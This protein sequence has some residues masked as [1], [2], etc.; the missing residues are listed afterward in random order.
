MAK[1]T[2]VIH[3]AFDPSGAQSQLDA[4]LKKQ[5]PVIRIGSM[6]DGL[7]DVGKIVADMTKQIEE[8]LTHTDFG[9][10]LAES[11]QASSG[12][13][14]S[15]I[16]D[17]IAKGI[18]QGS[19]K[20]AA[21]DISRTV[22]GNAGSNQPTQATVGFQ[23]GKTT[24]GNSYGTVAAREA[25]E[26]T[27]GV[28]H[29]TAA[30]AT[31]RY[32][33]QDRITNMRKL[34]SSYQNY[35]TNDEEKEILKRIIKDRE[36]EERRYRKLGRT[37]EADE[38]ARQRTEL[39]ALSR[40][41]VPIQI[42]LQGE[43]SEGRSVTT[44]Q[45]RGNQTYVYDTGKRDKDDNIIYASKT[46]PTGEWY[47]ASSTL[48][49]DYESQEKA[50]K[51]AEKIA[52]RNAKAYNSRTDRIS[53][54]RTQALTQGVDKNADVQNAFAAAEK[55][56][57][58]LKFDPNNAEA[59]EKYNQAMRD[60]GE[61]IAK[62]SAQQKDQE[63]T[64]KK[65]QSER[66][67]SA[68]VANQR[69]RQEE[70]KRKA[71]EKTYESQQS[72]LSNARSEIDKYQLQ[73]NK[74][75]TDAL[76][77][78]EEA[79]ATF[80]TERT[81]ESARAATE[82]YNALQ[83]AIQ[84]AAN[85]QKRLNEEAQAASKTIDSQK[86]GIAAL[87]SKA[88]NKNVDLEQGELQE[89]KK[90]LE[91]A[92]LSYETTHSEEDV[93]R[94]AD[95][96][97]DLSVA[98]DQAAQNQ[99]NLQSQAAR[100]NAF[101]K[102]VADIQSQQDRMKNSGLTF[103]DEQNSKVAEAAKKAQEAAA[104]LRDNPQDTSAPAKDTE[105]YEA[106]K[107]VIEECITAT[108][109]LNTEQQKRTSNANAVTIAKTKMEEKTADAQS[110]LNQLSGAN[111]ERATT[112]SGTL[113]AA[114]DNAK[115]KYN[116][117][118]GT[119]SDD[120][121]G[122]TA[123]LQ[124]Y[125]AAFNQ[126]TAAISS[127][128]KAL[129]EFNKESK[130]QDQGKILASKIETQKSKI[131]NFMQENR[132][133]ITEEQK[134]KLKDFLQNLNN[135][136]SPA[137]LRQIATDFASI[138]EAVKG[139]SGAVN[140][141][142]S[143]FKT[144]VKT[145]LPV[146]GG[147][148]LFRK[149][150]GEFK[151]MAQ[152]TTAIDTA[153]TSF[154]QT[155]TATS[156]QFNT[157][158]T[159]G[160]AKSKDLGINVTD[161]INAATEFSRLGESFADSAV[162][163]EAS[164]KLKNIGADI[165]DV[166][167][168]SS[169]LIATMKG[170]GLASKDV[171]RI[172]DAMTYIGNS[173]PITAGGVGDALQR[174]AASMSAAGNSMEQ[175][176]AL[177]TSGNAIVQAPERVGS[178]LN[179]LAL[180]IRGSKA[181]LSELGEETD[182][183]CESVSKMRKQVKALSGVDIML[184]ATQYKD[185]YTIMKEIS[186]VWDSLTD[187]N[188]AALTEALF[189]KMRANVGNSI[190][191]NFDIAEDVLE[192][193]TSGKAAGYTESAYGTYLDSV[194]AKAQQLKTTFQE[195]S[196]VIADSNLLKAGYDIGTTV[197]ES[198]TA[199]VKA[200]TSLSNTLGLANSSLG[201]L[202]GL[203]TVAFTALSKLS[204]VPLWDFSGNGKGLIN[205]VRITGAQANALRTVQDNNYGILSPYFQTGLVPSGQGLHIGDLPQS[206][207]EGLHNAGAYLS[208]MRTEAGMT[209]EQLDQ[210]YQKQRGIIHA[211]VQLGSQ[212]GSVWSNIAKGLKSTILQMGIVYIA[213]LGIS[214]LANAIDKSVNAR[215]YSMQAAEE[216]YKNSR[217]VQ[218]EIETRNKTVE[219][220]IDVV[221]KYRDKVGAK[222]ENLGLSTDEMAEYQAAANA[223]GE[224]LPDLV[225]YWDES[226]NAVLRA[227]DKVDQ[228]TEALQR[229]NLVTL[230]T[231]W[232]EDA[233]DL[234]KGANA[235]VNNKNTDWKSVWAGDP[236]D[237]TNVN[238]YNNAVNYVGE[239]SVVAAIN[240]ILSTVD[241]PKERRRQ[242]S[243]L[244]QNVYKNVN[245]GL[246]YERIHGRS[247][248]EVLYGD[249]DDLAQVDSWKRQGYDMEQY[250]APWFFTQMAKNGSP[251]SSNIRFDDKSWG[252]F[253]G[254][255][256]SASS[257]WNSITTKAGSQLNSVALRSFDI[258]TNPFSRYSI[259]GG[260]SNIQADT[261]AIVRRAIAGMDLSDLLGI[262]ASNANDIS[263]Y[264]ENSILKPLVSGS[265]YQQALTEFST[266]AS[267][268]DT[269]T[270]T[271]GQ[272]NAARQRAKTAADEADLN[273]DIADAIAD[274]VFDSDYYGDRVAHVTDLISDEWDGF[275]ES[276]TKPMLDFA[277]GIDLFDGNKQV[278][279]TMDQFF[280]AYAEFLNNMNNQWSDMK[281]TVEKMNE[282]QKTF[283]TV[284]SN[285][286]KNGYLS[287]EDVDSVLAAN[288]A[289][290]G[291]LKYGVGGY[292]FDQE[293]AQQ[294]MS[295]E[296][297]VLMDENSA[298]IGRNSEAI[299]KAEQKLAALGE[300]TENETA[301][302][303]KQR[304]THQETIDTLKKENNRRAM[305][306]EQ[307]AF[308]DTP[309]GRWLAMQDSPEAG[310]GFRGLKGAVDAVR[311]GV[312]TGR[313]FTTAFKTSGDV[314]FGEDSGW[315]DWD[316][317][318]VDKKLKSFEKL[319]D[320]NGQFSVGNM[321][322]WFQAAG[323][324]NENG[325]WTRT[326]TFD[327]LAD[328][329]AQDVE[330]FGPMGKQ[331]LAQVLMAASEYVGWDQLGFKPE[332]LTEFL[333][334]T[335]EEDANTTAVNANTVA[336]N[337][338]TAALGGIVSEGGLTE[339]GNIT[340]EK[341][342]T[343]I[344]VET[345]PDE[346]GK[347]SVVGKDAE[348]NTVGSYG[349]FK[350][351]TTAQ[352]VA[353]IIDAA[354][355]RGIYYTA[356]DIEKISQTSN[357]DWSTFAQSQLT[358]GSQLITS[359][360]NLNG[361]ADALT[362]AAGV[363]EEAVGGGSSGSGGEGEGKGENAG[364]EPHYEP[365]TKETKDYW[366]Q[367]DKLYKASAANAEKKELAEAA[368]AKAYEDGVKRTEQIKAHA[369][370]EE[371]QEQLRQDIDDDWL[372]K[373][374][375]HQEALQ[376]E[377]IDGEVKS[378]HERLMSDLREQGSTEAEKLKAQR[379]AQRET[380]AERREAE[381][382]APQKAA[383]T[384]YSIQ[385]R[386]Q[387][388]KKA[389]EI[390]QK[391]IQPALTERQDLINDITDILATDKSMA[392][393]KWFRDN[394]GVD[395]SRDLEAYDNETL[396]T[397]L[398]QLTDVVTQ[399]A[400][401][402]AQRDG[403]KRTQQV[404]EAQEEAEW[405]TT[406][407][408]HQESLRQDIIKG[409][410][411]QLWE[412]AIAANNKLKEATVE[413]QNATIETP[414]TTEPEIPSMTLSPESMN[415]PASYY[416]ALKNGLATNDYG[417]Y[418]LPTLYALE[419]G[420]SDMIN[421]IDDQFDWDSYDVLGTKDQAAMLMNWLVDHSGG[422]LPESAKQPLSTDEVTV[423]ADSTVVESPAPPETT[424]PEPT[425]APEKTYENFEEPYGGYNSPYTYAL[426]TGLFDR[427][428]ELEELT[429]DLFDWDAFD[430][431]SSADQM[432]TFDSWISSHQ[433][434]QDTSIDADN[435]GFMEAN[436]EVEA[437]GEEPVTKPINGD[438]SGANAAIDQIRAKAAEGAQMPITIITPDTSGGSNSSTEDGDSFASGIPS[439]P[440]GPSLVGEAGD[441]I[442]VDT[443]RGSW[444]L[445]Q[446]PEL[447]N[448]N[449][450]DIVYNAK[451]TSELLRR[452]QA[453]GGSAHAK[454]L[455]GNAYEGGLFAQIWQ[456]FVGLWSN[457]NKKPSG[458]SGGGNKDSG[459]AA[460]EMTD[461]FNKL[462][463]WIERLLAVAKEKTDKLVDSVK[464]LVN[465][466]S[467]NNR[468]DQAI[469]AAQ[470]EQKVNRR[471]AARYR[472]QADDTAK[473]YGLSASYV[474]KIQEGKLD[475]ESLSEET[476]AKVAEYKKWY[477]KALA[478]ESRIEEL[479][480]QIKELQLSKFDNIVDYYTG[481]VDYRKSLQAVSSANV[482]YKNASGKTLTKYDFTPQLHA[483]GF[484]RSNLQS[485]RDAMQKQFDDLIK[486]GTIREG[487]EN[488]YKYK[489]AI[490]DLDEQILKADTDIQKVQDEINR[491][492]LTKL[493]YALNALKRIST[494]IQNIFSLN[495]AQN[496]TP[497]TDEE[498]DTTTGYYNDLIKNGMKQIKN[499]KDQRK[500]LVGMLDGLDKNSE[501]YQEILGEIDQI[502]ASIASVM[503]DQEQW[504]D[505]II[506][507]QIE[508][509][510][511]QREELEKQND[512]YKKQKEYEEAL[513]ELEKART[514]KTKLIFREGKGFQY[515]ADED[516]IRE[517]Q[518]RVDDLRHQQIIDKIDEV[519]D[520][521]EDSKRDDNVYDQTGENQLKAYAAGGVNT[522][523]GIAQLDGTTNSPEVVFNASD[524]GKL[525][526]LVHNTS[527]LSDFVADSVMNSLKAHVMPSVDSANKVVS[528]A[529]GD[530][531][532]EGVQNSNDL[533]RQ[534]ITAL[535][536]QILQDLHMN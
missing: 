140:P 178:A 350:D 454:G 435:S 47:T 530:I 427:I 6:L 388:L 117:L 303:K 273:G 377:I 506:D 351:A 518:E 366:D 414:E 533:A 187:I 348:G 401:E 113:Q 341:A 72:K 463:D 313:R 523:T 33:Q 220:N 482:D 412:Q 525:Y 76:K 206:D 269:G 48:T 26:E 290:G 418:A 480:D 292:F 240:N 375:E 154:K 21:T 448:L 69:R 405:H 153:M 467:R 162:L 470:A 175:T 81:V 327:D 368:A 486:N 230:T 337:T 107:S 371:H 170:F 222:G 297:R 221:Q 7:G 319:Y 89:K 398:S 433:P 334:K 492:P 279:M 475:I 306:I 97:R 272:V 267:G 147:V 293:A 225:A 332:D 131:Q 183:Y 369:A 248:A 309:Y 121:A 380:E 44:V 356:D 5:H 18:A 390:D 340:S 514:Q 195:L 133:W 330:G 505:A 261:L 4:W 124:A 504:N 56:N 458:E 499:L 476:K 443:K 71:D 301:D 10:R 263:T 305:L 446:G 94:Y 276:L 12:R 466:W 300:E 396:G 329:M 228:Y 103:T 219:E 68:R 246:D 235:A 20:K 312:T 151:K 532:L 456:G 359:A 321:Q 326:L 534:I 237:W 324:M 52:E 270:R 234:V 421:N 127:A 413:A 288:K 79:S 393:E 298:A 8:N 91:E 144:L 281:T 419:S 268:F 278:S 9:T 78:A 238:R 42:T 447:L 172:T 204:K 483:L 168:A 294:I 354:Q 226:G 189:G 517:A 84:S 3:S 277:N 249:Q 349:T 317:D 169:Y 199:V 40:G 104:Y 63:K 378:L 508:S 299:T 389:G 444:H 346:N 227:K 177:I 102:R 490:A 165:R 338:L 323:V 347:V 275:A 502:D 513:L 531:R 211:G 22:I 520:E 384:D 392:N 363:L 27:W 243:D 125:N 136:N 417:G 364:N 186:E 164:I 481:R 394:L 182:E 509:Q 285:Q 90:A 194:E 57:E 251:L 30:H 130:E 224:A 50:A 82:A 62:V 214:A 80:D 383:E 385:Q 494:E 35:A 361:A 185:T 429:G 333:G 274:T 173:Y 296:R 439:A 479:A 516:A 112:A 453:M 515:E 75:V 129:S 519:I 382:T 241:D 159:Q 408:D 116:A 60:L 487:D 316:Q 46:L 474:K 236:N 87:K 262:G 322:K 423:E 110:L 438:P 198:I 256:Q 23:G 503:Q 455:N 55:V 126:L 39:G 345:A 449:K 14:Q 291:A 24:K 120:V 28:K 205:G 283:N 425:P 524:A 265:T 331:M 202:P 215:K 358:A 510:R 260:Y 386:K 395:W 190:L 493:E 302:I 252:K 255:F 201:A 70:A 284:L 208:L 163:G 344:T 436:E 370:Q 353:E 95:A 432:A 217:S 231:D 229:A 36:A 496:W 320:E 521:L 105:A 360:N 245:K 336:L 411:K 426:E 352:S 335:E 445:T 43:D 526:D 152:E 507:L 16:Q 452:H 132:Q 511:R 34:S 181:E 469:K 357:T 41:Q 374:D 325:K 38:L 536:N 32:S 210:V 339:K 409:E 304:K 207:L 491:L 233:D 59:V 286:S 93:R 203:A 431:M 157:F 31:T 174:S 434:P 280:E 355:K 29:D 315:Q 74:E 410:M 53:R 86:N 223:L 15:I 485:E 67:E 244:L 428:A 362:V 442:V 416:E 143:N 149:L 134:Q 477:D 440:G 472:K 160:I 308:Q 19:I 193:L 200:V 54:L 328:A 11:I 253:M 473:K 150:V 128:K 343:V 98:I 282:S 158:L 488:Y 365:G 391:I 462:Y 271:I 342:K 478:A 441:E 232:D 404:K 179:V 498:I 137:G 197:L 415:T 400:V 461:A 141:F 318:K 257:N 247:I 402:K 64:E 100:E 500:I 289:Y 420:L 379:Q 424:E 484:Q 209:A 77:K 2:I 61:T 407:D 314:L 457:K 101:V 122:Q 196:T 399:K 373:I 310:D 161:Y 512:Q 381:L 406:V 45:R 254:A 460:K 111:T 527:N 115:D 258:I 58:T 422:T 459:K 51:E 295:D 471:A 88:A 212:Q 259:E 1:L 37:E 66:K 403:D 85:E 139:A 146:G 167:D 528:I 437:A 106:L 96:Y 135:V 287:M 451:Q 99:K 148:V 166:T 522:H 180:R 176:I 188:Q 109:R 142:V 495:Q 464:D 171:D 13:I 114:L 156:T 497:I 266:V 430:A 184:N 376:R 73:G 242:V 307:L 65:L 123:A 501:K 372:D 465:Y 155:T 83:E 397:I 191:S 213:M 138:Q 17:S 468:V 387:A 450:G 489:K 311:E 25:I 92:A 367:Q 119:S 216:A 264:I 192:D 529:I 535:P 218:D 239:E 145:I 250:Y 49:D 108:K 118:Q